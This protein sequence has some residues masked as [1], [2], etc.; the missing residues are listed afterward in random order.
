VLVNWPPALEELGYDN[1]VP[2]NAEHFV[3]VLEGRQARGEMAFNTLAYSVKMTAR[4][5]AALL[6]LMWEHRDNLRLP[7]KTAVSI[8][9]TG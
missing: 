6:A 4:Q 8:S 9:P 2:F 5:I 7:P 3:S 1:V